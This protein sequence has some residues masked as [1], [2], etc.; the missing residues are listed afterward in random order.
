MNEVDPFNFT[1]RI[2]IFP[3]KSEKKKV[4]KEKEG[5]R[6]GVDMSVL[7]EGCISKIVSRTSPKDACRACVVSPKFRN[8]VESD[9]VWV[10]FLPSDYESVIAR[11]S[12]S[13]NCTSKKELY[14]YLSRNPILIDDSKK[15]FAITI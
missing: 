3:T 15:V 12:D 14:L 4:A 2:C 6:N 1:L 7:P 13:L 8:I 10:R 9:V 11:S 5:E